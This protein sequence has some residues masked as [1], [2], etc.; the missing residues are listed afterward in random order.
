MA[1]RNTCILKD[2]QK[3]WSVTSGQWSARERREPF[4]AMQSLPSAAADSGGRT[5]RVSILAD[6]VEA[7]CSRSEKQADARL[8]RGVHAH[9]RVAVMRRGYGKKRRL[10]TPYKPEKKRGFISHAN[11]C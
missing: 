11:P 9:G 3:Q 10:G 5:G 1:V 4:V 8:N 7:G 6:R 2:L